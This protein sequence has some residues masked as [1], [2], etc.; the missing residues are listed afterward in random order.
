MRSNTLSVGMRPEVAS[1]VSIR[2]EDAKRSL[3]SE[4]IEIR[5][6]KMAA[7]P[8]YIVIPTCVTREGTF[9]CA[10]LSDSARDFSTGEFGGTIEQSYGATKRGFSY[11]DIQID[12]QN[13]NFIP[14]PQGAQGDAA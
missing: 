3:K 9:H 14:A 4:T 2:A 7:D 12:C 11:R 5:K 1:W 6:E 13:E 8:A 10:A